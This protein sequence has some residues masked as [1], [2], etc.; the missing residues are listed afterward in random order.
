MIAK[1]QTKRVMLTLISNEMFLDVRLSVI[2]QKQNYYSVLTFNVPEYNVVNFGF[3][4][5]DCCM[6]IK[7]KVNVTS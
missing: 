4:S 2:I 7:K 3:G 6:P 1:C 5:P